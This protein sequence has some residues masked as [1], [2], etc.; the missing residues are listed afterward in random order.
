KSERVNLRTLSEGKW[1][2]GTSEIPT[3]LD[4]L[5]NKHPKLIDVLGDRLLA[6]VK[7]GA[8]QL[9][10]YSREQINAITGGNAEELTLFKPICFGKEIVKYGIKTS[11]KFLFFPYNFVDG[12]QQVI[13][14]A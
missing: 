13:D 14:L 10:I 9:F 8:N 7:T 6:G 5:S 1:V 12:K 4:K 3:L 11:D 2:L